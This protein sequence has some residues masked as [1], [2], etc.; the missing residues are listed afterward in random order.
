VFSLAQHGTS[1]Y[2]KPPQGAGIFCK[3]K[4]AEHPTSPIAQLA[5]LTVQEANMAT[6]AERDPTVQ[7]LAAVKLKLSGAANSQLKKAREV[8]SSIRGPVQPRH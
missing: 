2:S 3:L 6:P 7:K 5:G 1:Q 8:Q 4:N